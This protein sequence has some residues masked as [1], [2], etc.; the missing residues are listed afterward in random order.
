MGKKFGYDEQ[1]VE[2]L[3]GQHDMDEQTRKLFVETKKK[4]KDLAQWVRENVPSSAL[5][6]T[7]I[8]K[9]FE[10]KNCATIA[11]IVD[12]AQ[13]ERAVDQNV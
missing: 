8:N 7:A 9:I 2:D 13:K 5:Q 6:T 1:A 10:G 12:R 11:I 4:F 3:F